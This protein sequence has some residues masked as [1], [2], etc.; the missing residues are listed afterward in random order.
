MKRLHL[1]LLG[2]FLVRVADGRAIHVR[3]R[4]AQA[5]L[6]YL[7]MRPG[8][9]QPREKL[10]ALL[11]GE[12]AP[13]RARHS[14]RQTLTSL[15]EDLHS[16]RAPRPLLGGD[17]VCLDGDLV[18]TDVT[19]FEQLS[20]S[21]ETA[22]LEQAAAMYR[23]DLL[24]GIAVEGEAFEEWLAAERER[25]R[26]TALH[27]LDRLLATRM[28]A[29]ATAP[30]V[31]AAIQLLRVDPMR[32]DV[33]RV[34]MRLYAREGRRPA[35]IQQYRAC[36]AIL[37]RELDLAPENETAVLYRA[38]LAQRSRSLAARSETVRLQSLAAT[39]AV[40]RSAFPEAV[41]CLE[42]ALGAS[43]R[44]LNGRARLTRSE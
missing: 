42:Q 27:V 38:I 44:E 8:E 24:E 26:A 16:W 6:A 15:R 5:L 21:A 40:A 2:P 13:A 7:A 20:D 23:G 35:A 4:K 31:Q 9:R 12:A 17:A 1:S 28:A 30:I 37:R 11:W 36:A 10:I 43:E 3:R 33:H 41:A 32:E 18:T 14:L 22:S 39:G 34:L 25:L 29:G 19:T